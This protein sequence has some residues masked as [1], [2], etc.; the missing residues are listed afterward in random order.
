MVRDVDVLRTIGENN[1]LFVNLTITTLNVELA[2][3]LEPRAP[4]PDLRLEAMRT[5]NQA[6]YYIVTTSSL[7]RYYLVTTSLLPRYY[8]VVPLD[9]VPSP[10]FVWPDSTAK[11]CVQAGKCLW[12]GSKSVKSHNPY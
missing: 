6:A 2:R 7:R 8:L 9:L 11:Q 1:Q 10:A 5:L 4:R 3:I 12:I